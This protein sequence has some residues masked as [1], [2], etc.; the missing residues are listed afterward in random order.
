ML[1]TYCT[2]FFKEAKS[3]GTISEEDDEEVK[4]GSTEGELIL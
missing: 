4:G 1:L 3:A 2:I